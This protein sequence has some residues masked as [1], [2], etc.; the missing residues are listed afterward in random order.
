M[1]SAATIPG[2]SISATSAGRNA[3]LGTPVAR[4][5]DSAAV[6]VTADTEP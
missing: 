6:N 2:I 1:T 3:S 4:A 5:K